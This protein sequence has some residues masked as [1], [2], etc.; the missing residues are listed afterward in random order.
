MKLTKCFA[1]CEMEI[2]TDTVLEDDRRILGRMWMEI[3][4][5]EA[6]D[7]LLT[8]EVLNSVAGTCLGTR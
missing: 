6:E 2:G 7:E 3:S 5:K 4:K 1:A 8:S